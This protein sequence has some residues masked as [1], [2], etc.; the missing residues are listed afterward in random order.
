[1]ASQLPV[2]RPGIASETGTRGRSDRGETST[3]GGSD[4]GETSTAAG[5]TAEV[6]IKNPSVEI[7]EP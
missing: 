7:P 6:E 1:M 4:R 5:Q 2:A 3:R